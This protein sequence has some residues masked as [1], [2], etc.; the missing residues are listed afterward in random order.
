MAELGIEHFLF[1]SAALFVIGMTGLLTRRNLLVIFMCVEL[2]LTS[3]NISLV[4]FGWETNTLNGQIFAIFAISIAA[5][6]AAVGLGI[7][8]AL[9]RRIRS[10]DVADI[11]E[12][13]D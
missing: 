2:I 9:S 1:L 6:E 8:L 13:R 3:V 11:R 7:I 10:V 4:A 5:A 12:L